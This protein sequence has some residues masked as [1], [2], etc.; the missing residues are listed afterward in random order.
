MR[1]QTTKLHIKLLTPKLTF[2]TM[3]KIF[4]VIA[5][6]AIV[7]FAQAQSGML[8]PTFGD[9][10]IVISSITAEY[11]FGN[12][13][14]TQADGKIVT[15]GHTGLPG[16]YDVAVVRYNDDGSNDNTFGTDGMVVVA[17]TAHSDYALGMAIQPDGKIVLGGYIYGGPST[18]VLLIRL[19][20]DG[21]PDES[22][23]TN[24]I[25]ITD[26]GG[27]IEVAEAIA[28]QDDGKI[29]LGGDHED[30][31][32]VIRYNTDGT[33]DNTYGD[34]GL[35]TANV[36]AGSCYIKSIAIQDDGKVVAG[37]MGFNELSNFGFATAR[38]NTDGSLD[39]GFA[40]DGTKL[41]NIGQGHDFILGVDFQSD[42]KIILGGHTWV[43]NQPILQYDF[44]AIRLNQN[45]TIDN[46]FGN[47]GSATVNIT[48]G[49]NYV[50]GMVVQSDDK[51]VL[52]GYVVDV[53]DYDLGIARLTAGGELDSE[54]GTN[55]VTR[56]DID[57]KT[58]NTN[59]I[60][61]QPD[62]K[63][64]TAGYT[65]TN[66]F[67]QLLVVRYT[68]EIGGGDP[69]VEITTGEITNISV[70]ATFTPVDGCATYY[71]LL[72]TQAEMEMWS[73][74]L[75]VS[76]DSLVQMWGIE[77][78]EAYTH[79]WNEQMPNTEY[80]LYA[81]PLDTNGMA[82]PL[83]TITCTTLT[84]GGNGLAEMDVQVTDIADSSVRLIATPN[85]QTAMFFDG[86]ITASYFNEIGEDSA[87]SVMQNNG[88]PQYVTDDWVWTGLEPATE[89]YAIAIGKNALDEW[90]PATI[91]AFSTLTVGINDPEESQATMNIFPMP[92]NGAFTFIAPDNEAGTIRIFNIKG[93][94]V[95]EQAVSG[96]QNA[97][98]ARNLSRGLYH[99][100]FTSK[101]K[102]ITVSEKLLIAK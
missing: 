38:F 64:V 70:E 37:G 28:I 50:T 33:L 85:D 98:D 2:I 11:N 17:A 60:A 4:T 73:T 16:S 84:G 101:S 53:E 100:Q 102:A 69:A 94:V 21:T 8:D 54:F 86:L 99:L 93:Q 42:G 20:T 30:S 26:F 45:G 83:S 34:G 6:F 29:L 36:G 61:I 95:L 66:D 76:I 5:F 90:G 89:Y 63:I 81:R 65:E 88:Y 14:A 35:A 82:W 67:P 44:A 15:S 24:G 49:S 12:A 74:W 68:N 92:N 59:A 18:D 62:G 56:T 97:I 75:G 10:G 31:F 78:T 48:F 51:V 3:R 13:I 47:Q 23:G 58:D 40:D 9:G 19:N 96:Q 71:A 41:F 72:S 91:V 43:A 22:F 80:T 39:T 7:A 79:L 27:S 77:K 87:V 57:K 55:G 46:T 25:V 52:S 1:H 32:M